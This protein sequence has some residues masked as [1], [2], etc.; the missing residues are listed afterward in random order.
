[1][2]TYRAYGQR[3]RFKQHAVATQSVLECGVGCVRAHSII[4]RTIDHSAR[5]RSVQFRCYTYISLFNDT[6]YYYMFSH[7]TLLVTVC[8]QNS[9]NHKISAELTRK[10]KC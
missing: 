7:W 4:G 5:C 8:S 2:F 3:D 1:V 9:L 10:M 6:F